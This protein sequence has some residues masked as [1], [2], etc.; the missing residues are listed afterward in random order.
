ML[1]IEGAKIIQT[2]PSGNNR[3]WPQEFTVLEKTE[4]GFV[5]YPVL[6]ND[7][8]TAISLNDPMSIIFNANGY[9]YGLFP[10][11]IK[12]LELWDELADVTKGSELIN[13]Y[14][15][16]LEQNEVIPQEYLNKLLDLV[17]T[18]ENQLLTGQMLGQIQTI[19]WNLL[20]EDERNNAAPDLEEIMWTQMIA[21]DESSKKKTFFNAFRNIAISDTQVQKVY[22]IWLNELEIDGLNLSETDY[23]SMA[24]NL[25]IKMPEKSGEII[26]TQLDNIENSDRKRRFEFISPAL[27]GDQQIRDDFFE[28]LKDEENRQ[29]ESWV[30]GALGYL[31]HPLRVDV[32]EKYILPSL[33]LLQEIQVTGDIF[34]PTRW[35]DVTLGSY[36][37]DS[38]V[39]T[40]RNFLDEHPDYNDQLRMKILQSADGMFRANRIKN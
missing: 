7:V 31:H 37:S 10:A 27:S 18:E 23:I 26:S 29:T 5:H 28:S 2:D 19:Y 22:D 16:M 32:S 33:E 39:Q 20:N 14:E 4:S 40:V 35:L 8:Q 21:Q 1:Y 12:N 13:L 24:G 3:V 11:S 36:S 25:A 17:Q 9:G 30:L 6:S 15:N 38:A 34:F